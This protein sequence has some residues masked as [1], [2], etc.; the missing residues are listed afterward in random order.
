MDNI[1]S[2]VIGTFCVV[3]GGVN[4]GQWTFSGKRSSLLTG[5]VVFAIGVFNIVLF[6]L[7]NS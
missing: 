6:V 1:F 3:V 5:L 4:F 2:L 7:R